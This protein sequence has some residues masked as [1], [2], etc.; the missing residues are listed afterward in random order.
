MK[1]LNSS[2]LTISSFSVIV[3][4]AAFVGYIVMT[5]LNERGHRYRYKFTTDS[6]GRILRSNPNFK[7]DFPQTM[8][9]Y[10]NLAHFSEDNLSAIKLTNFEEDEFIACSTKK[11]SNGNPTTRRQPNRAR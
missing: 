10:D 4:V 3:V 6:E 11:L 9:I 1:N 5:G 7:E 2:L 8:R